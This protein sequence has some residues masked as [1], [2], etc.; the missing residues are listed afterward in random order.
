[1]TLSYKMP[2]KIIL[3]LDV[4]KITVSDLAAR[5]GVSRSMVVAVATNRATSRRVSD[6]ID[7]FVQENLKPELIHLLDEL[8]N[9]FR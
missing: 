8:E 7:E 9:Q 3:A 5:I 4:A 6:G 1:M 2:K